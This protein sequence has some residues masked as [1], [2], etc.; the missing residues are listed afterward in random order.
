MVAFLKENNIRML[1][2]FSCNSVGM[3]HEGDVTVARREAECNSDS[4]KCNMPTL[5]YEKTMLHSFCYMIDFYL[6]D[7]LKFVIGQKHWHT[8]RL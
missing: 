3:L 1:Y 7:Q 5:L 2:W 8:N 6:Y 4:P